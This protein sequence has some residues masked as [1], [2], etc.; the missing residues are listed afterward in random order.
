MFQGKGGYIVSGHQ[1]CPFDCIRHAIFQV[2]C[3]YHSRNASRHVY[4]CRGL[5]H[6]VEAAVCVL[7]GGGHDIDET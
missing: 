1:P 7:I 6:R 2:A 3:V 5:R 4:I